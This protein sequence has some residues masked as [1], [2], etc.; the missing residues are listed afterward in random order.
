MQFFRDGM[1]VFDEYRVIYGRYKISV[2]S[3]FVGNFKSYKKFYTMILMSPIATN[4]FDNYSW[5]EY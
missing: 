2:E 3:F 1:F 5:L 4:L